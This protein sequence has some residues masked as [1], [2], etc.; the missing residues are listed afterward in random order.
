MKKLLF[1]T[2]LLAAVCPIV[3]LTGCQ[4]FNT[5]AGGVKNKNIVAG[6]DT[7][8]GNIEASLTGTAETAPCS[9]SLWFGRRRVWYASVKDESNVKYLP[10]I[11]KASN[12]SLGITAGATGITISQ[13]ASGNNASDAEKTKE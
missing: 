10:E 11:V 2:V 5:L 4:A 12:S 1:P 9:I 6:S 13:G 7:W 3:F 8:G